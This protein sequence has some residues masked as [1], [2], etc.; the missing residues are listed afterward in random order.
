MVVS[1]ASVFVATHEKYIVAVYTDDKK[2]SA[3]DKAIL[4]VRV[5]VSCILTISKHHRRHP[6]N[7]FRHCYAFMTAQLIDG[8]QQGHRLT[9]DMCQSSSVFKIGRSAVR[10]CTTSIVHDP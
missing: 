4:R 3:T 6:T 10:L 7:D 9:A 5:P 8:I 1:R 2:A